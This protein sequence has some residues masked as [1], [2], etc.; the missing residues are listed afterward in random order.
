MSIVVTTRSSAAAVAEIDPHFIRFETNRANNVVISSISGMSVDIVN[1]ILIYLARG[2]EKKAKAF[3]DEKKRL[4]KSKTFVSLKHS[5][6][7]VHNSTRYFRSC[8]K[9][10]FVFPNILHTI[11][12]TSSLLVRRATLPKNSTWTTQPVDC[13]INNLL[14]FIKYNATKNLMTYTRLLCMYVLNI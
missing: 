14:F 4:R 5:K 9:Y 7:S 10:L 2:E 8:N 6:N 12:W 1:R 13:R 11:L 3:Y